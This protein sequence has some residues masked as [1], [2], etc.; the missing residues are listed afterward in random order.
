MKSLSQTP[1][2]TIGSGSGGG[3]GITSSGSINGP[4]HHQ[5]Q[6][7]HPQLLMMSNNIYDNAA[8]IY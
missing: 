1:A 6:Q 8:D 7:Q 5:Q 3:V 2:A 4:N